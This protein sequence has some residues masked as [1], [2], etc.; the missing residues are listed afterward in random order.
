MPPSLL[1]QDTIDKFD[2]HGPLKS[3]EYQWSIEEAKL[4]LILDDLHSQNS[5]SLKYLSGVTTPA[6]F[7]S[8]T[9]TR[10]FEV[11]ELVLVPLTS[12]ICMKKQTEAVQSGSVF[13]KTYK[14]PKGVV[15]NIVLVPSGGMKMPKVETSTG[16][17]GLKQTPHSFVIPFWLVQ[18]SGDHGVHNMKLKVMKSKVFSIGACTSFDKQ[19]R[20]QEG[21]RP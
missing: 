7:R 5:T 2:D 9:A 12:T 14:D 21:R 4:K 10:S 3:A 18:D 6:R 11:E 8:P 19:M 16:V 15:F 13:V 1:F 17:G 20:H